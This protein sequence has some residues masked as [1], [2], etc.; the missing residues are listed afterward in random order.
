M[1]IVNIV[2]LSFWQKI[3]VY[4]FIL[5]P[6]YLIPYAI[7]KYINSSFKYEYGIQDFV[8]ILFMLLSSFGFIYIKQPLL[9]FVNLYLLGKFLIIA[10]QSLLKN[11]HKEI[12]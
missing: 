6:I 5:S 10:N 8:Q 3:F 11:K 1:K 4:S 2:T 7:E 12:Y 9:I